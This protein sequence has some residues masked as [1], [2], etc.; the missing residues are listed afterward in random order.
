MCA[1]AIGSI[2]PS[3]AQSL[4]KKVL[5]DSSTSVQIAAAFSLC[6]IAPGDRAAA[7][8]Q[9][10][11]LLALEEA[12]DL[13]AQALV[14]IGKDA[15]APLAA[16]ARI[17]QH[18][19]TWRLACIDVLGEI[20]NPAAAELITAINDATIAE[21]AC[22]G[23]CNIGQSTVPALLIAADDEA[24]FNPAARERIR[25]LVRD[26]HD[27]LGGG[28]GDSAW[29][30]AHPLAR[31][32]RDEIRR[33]IGALGSLNLLG[34]GAS[35]SPS[36]GSGLS[37]VLNSG[38]GGD[39]GSSGSGIGG[40]GNRDASAGSEPPQPP[41]PA[42]D[43]GYKSVKVFYGTNR[44]PLAASALT[45]IPWFS[46]Q[47]VAIV[48]LAICLGCL[49]WQQPRS[50]F[51]VSACAVGLAVL[52]VPTLPFYQR[53]P[54][55]LFD[56]STVEY[57]GEYSD[58]VEMGVC[59]VTVPESHET[60]ELEGPS[61]LNLEF[62]VDPEKH[63]ILRSTQRLASD[64]FF[65]ELDGEMVRQGRSVLVFIHGYNVSFADAARRTAQM[66]SDLKYPG[67][68]VFYSWPSQANWYKY[69]LDEK[70]VELSVSQLQSFLLEVAERSN[71]T[72]I[73]LVAH[74]M[75]NLRPH[76]RPEGDR[77]NGSRQRHP[78]Q[79]GC[80]RCPGY[81]LHDLQ[82]THCAVDRHQ[83]C[84]ASLSMLRLKTWPSLPR[85]NSTAAMPA[86]A[87]PA[88]TS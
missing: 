72:T 75:G 27:G 59:E 82:A 69:R 20:G 21:S 32:S 33:Q 35:S 86:R 12:R 31:L 51:A 76:Q 13:A 24:H 28:D 70:N 16:S 1:V 77:C 36:G 5:N 56:P 37:N 26:L 85:G 88:T 63:I 22:G 10:V 83:G 45:S 84:A 64:A 66:A 55:S 79:P 14:E 39:P 40:L 67:A 17:K 48:A 4:L 41:P 2:D 87:T 9:L 49:L 42:A 38:S 18:E 80:P 60:G 78:L 3:A 57:G 7:I 65:E 61:I 19:L 29:G 74:S 53:Q 73:N 15:V 58:R 25:Q 81:R 71:A 30:Q 54:S 23:L 62:N 6:K 34:S 47:S 8:Q 52:T 50:L 46:L 43:V 11:D 44:Q 68:A